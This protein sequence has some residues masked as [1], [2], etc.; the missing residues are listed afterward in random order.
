TDGRE[1]TGATSFSGIWGAAFSPN[2]DLVAMG[3]QDGSIK[4]WQTGTGA[5]ASTLKGQAARVT[6]LAFA[7]GGQLLLSGGA[8]GTLH[9]GSAANWQEVRQWSGDAPDINAVQFSP[10]GSEVAVSSGDGTVR[11]WEVTPRTEW[12]ALA[13]HSG[14]PVGVAFAPG[15]QLATAG[16]DG[17]VRV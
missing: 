11:L 14:A 3:F 6:A 16:S 13:S 15:G 5:L 7:P 4:V 10:D 2:D 9:L 8:D 17:V 1:V 12:P